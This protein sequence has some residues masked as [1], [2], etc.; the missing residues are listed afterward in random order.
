MP[1]KAEQSEATRTALV[2]AA[3]RLFAERGF[4]ET[5]TEAVVQAAG[6]TRGAL[7][8]HFRD[9]TALFQAVYEALE[10]Q[11]VDRIHAATE[12]I[13]DPMA[14]LRTGADAFLDA[15]LEPAVQRIVLLEAPAVLGW[16]TWR[17][18]DQAYGLG[19][20][21]AV[22]DVA[23]AAGAIRKA[24][25]EPLAHILLGGLVEGAMLL[26][27]SDDPDSA[28]RDVGEAVALLIDGLRTAPPRRGR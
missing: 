5:S 20:V 21:Q 22:L 18:I 28:R 11:V 24:P 10:Q 23:M 14:V 17:E 16:E 6:L 27:S 12:G 26:A 13:T 3:E 19:L 7:Y 2:Q 4:A 1:T 9:K 15:C 8:H 25:V